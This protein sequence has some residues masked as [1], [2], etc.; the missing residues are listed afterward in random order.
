M[1]ANKTINKITPSYNIA[2]H[3]MEN[4]RLFKHEIHDN[5]SG[6][7]HACSKIIQA[8]ITRQNYCMEC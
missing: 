4:I 5:K 2:Y 1:Y 8:Y 7:Y 3:N 6:T